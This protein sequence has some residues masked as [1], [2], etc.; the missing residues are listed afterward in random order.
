MNR[1][2]KYCNTLAQ[3]VYDSNIELIIPK[4]D[5]INQDKESSQFF[6]VILFKLNNGLESLNLFLLNLEAKPQLQIRFLYA[7]EHFYLIC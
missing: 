5:S 3:L 2:T 6:F 7:L 4:M 1:L